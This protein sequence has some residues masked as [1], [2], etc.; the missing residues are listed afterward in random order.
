MQDLLQNTGKLF[1]CLIQFWAE[2]L[3]CGG[4][5]VSADHNDLSVFANTNTSIE[6][7]GHGAQLIH[8]YINKWKL[9]SE[10]VCPVDE[11][12]QFVNTVMQ[13]VLCTGWNVNTG[14]SMEVGANG[15]LGTGCHNMFVPSGRPVTR[16]RWPDTTDR[17]VVAGGPW[18]P[19]GVGEGPPRMPWFL[20][21]KMNS[22]FSL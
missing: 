13:H 7:P 12:G 6:E 4:H 3:T 11:D 22:S 1:L 21:E 18:F 10:S 9:S 5:P 17:L 19:E 2:R 14:A 8:E 15:G 20:N 16:M